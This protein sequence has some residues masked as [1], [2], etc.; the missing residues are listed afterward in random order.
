MLA[1][2]EARTDRPDAADL[3]VA[4]SSLEWFRETAAPENLTRAR[5]RLRRINPERFT[6]QE[7]TEYLV[8][9]GAAL[10]L[11]NAPGAAAQIFASVLDGPSEIDPRARERILDWWASA[12]DIQARPQVDPGQRLYDEI[13]LRMQRELTSNPG[14]ATA[15]YWSVAAARGKG[16]LDAAWEG[17]MATWLRAPLAG[18]QGT[19]LR[20]DLDRLVQRAIVP[21]RARARNQ[22][23]EQMLAEWGLFKERWSA[24]PGAGEA[25][26]AGGAG[27]SG[28]AS[29][30]DPVAGERPEGK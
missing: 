11:D 13:S 12:L 17:A 3:I 6:P 5:E 29:G 1:A 23:V 7:R 19:A 28:P 26:E 24:P 30:S 14:S 9:L 2:D 21:E 4:R 8:G 27:G 15:S 25:G 18:S 16:D 10:Y 20:Q 22:S